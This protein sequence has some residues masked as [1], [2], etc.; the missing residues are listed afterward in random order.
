MR[1]HVGTSG[2]NYPEWRGSFYPPDIKAKDMFAF[3]AARFKAVEIN[4]TFYRVPTAKTTA[5]WLAQAPAG[6]RYILKAPRRIT[7]DKRLGPESAETLGYFCDNARVLGRHLGP[8]LFQLP[9]TFRCDVPR[10]EAFLARLPAD[11]LSAF[12]FRHDS[13]LTGEVYDVLRARGAA[14]CIADFGDR[15]TPLEVTARH[16]YFRLRDEGYVGADLDRWVGT[17]A[18][19]AAE[20]DDAFVFFKHEDEGKGAEFAKDFSERLAARGLDPA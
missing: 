12:E 5:A 11:V 3:Y 14:L 4:Y 15:T 13:W 1:I 9:P 18:E 16:G 6:F 20:W 8:L 19:R 2:Y 7:H 10:L 17:I